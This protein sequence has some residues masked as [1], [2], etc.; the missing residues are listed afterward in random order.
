MKSLPVHL[1]SCVVAILAIGCSQ[2]ATVKEQASN[3]R[4]QSDS[5]VVVETAA[6][7]TG[8][9]EEEPEEPTEPAIETSALDAPGFDFFPG[10]ITG[11]AR[12]DSIVSALS[13]IIKEFN[14][15]KFVTINMTHRY[16]DQVVGGTNTDACTWYYNAERQLCAAIKTYK[17]ERTTE[18]SNYLFRN[19]ELVAMT[20]DTDFYDEGAGYTNYVRIAT[21]ACPLCGVTISN[22]DGDGNELS[23]ISSVYTYENDLSGSH[24]EM[25]KTLKEVTEITKQGE[26][27]MA[28]VISESNTGPDTIK[29]SVDANLVRKFFKKVTVRD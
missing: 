22:D 26:R 25:I 18:S 13:R 7:E 1:C 23:E 10:S 11:D 12:E 20:L 6:A 28:Y 16:E 14:N 29:Y 9:A 2:Q 24:E 27:Y 19:N 3:P 15:E 21:T 8:V 17:S 5:G 4:A